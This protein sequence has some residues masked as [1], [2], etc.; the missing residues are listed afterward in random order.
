MSPNERDDLAIYLTAARLRSGAGGGGSVATPG[1]DQGDQPD[2]AVRGRTA[3]RIA[4]DRTSRVVRGDRL[5]W[6]GLSPAGVMRHF[7]EG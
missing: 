3:V 7:K 4:N 2:P 6:A 5:C 1:R